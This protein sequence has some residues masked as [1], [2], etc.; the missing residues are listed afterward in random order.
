MLNS[1]QTLAQSTVRIS[2]VSLHPMTAPGSSP[3]TRVFINAGQKHQIRH[4]RGVDGRKVT[5]IHDKEIRQKVVM[6]A[7]RR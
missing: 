1:H 4:R 7:I 6:H 2:V 3:V 5:R